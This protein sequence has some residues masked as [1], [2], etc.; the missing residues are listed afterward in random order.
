MMMS[1]FTEL[2]EEDEEQCSR[3]RQNDPSLIKLSL[4]LGSGII[5][6]TRIVRHYGKALEDNNVVESLRIN[7]GSSEFELS[8]DND[9]D[10]DPL[11]EFMEKS[12]SLQFVCLYHVRDVRAVGRLVFALSKSSSIKVLS[13]VQL[14]IPSDSLSNLFR[15][16]K[17]LRKLVL[18]FAPMIEAN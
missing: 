5:D 9:G 7:G 4:H 3:L 18:N 2:T 13:M 17:S 15:Q 14:S 8:L 6:N 10:L 11:N 12:Q 16:T 1:A